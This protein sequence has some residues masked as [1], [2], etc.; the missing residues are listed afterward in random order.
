MLHETLSIIRIMACDNKKKRLRTRDVKMR[1]V[2]KEF[3]RI[4]K[5]VRLG[6]PIAKSGYMYLKITE[7]HEGEHGWE[8]HIQALNTHGSKVIINQSNW[9]DFKNWVQGYGWNS[10]IR[11][12]TMAEWK[13]QYGKV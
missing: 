10:V 13:K 7:K 3:E 9:N 1:E 12:Y 2:D 8:L 5:T 6:K 4:V 11:P